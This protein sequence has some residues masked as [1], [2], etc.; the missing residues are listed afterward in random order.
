MYWISCTNLL[1]LH[2]VTFL[3]FCTIPSTLAT[4]TVLS[5]KVR[6]NTACLKVCSTIYLFPS[7]V[8][9]PNYFS[10]HFS[11]T[12]SFHTLPVSL[13]TNTTYHIHSISVFQFLFSRSAIIHT[14]SVNSH[15]K[16]REHVFY[17]EPFQIFKPSLDS[18]TP[19]TGRKFITQNNYKWWKLF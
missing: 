13:I 1:T 11:G 14:H 3:D 8:T 19:S 6:M 9:P 2:T 15:F 7:D 4:F 10:F 5:I 17:Y 18:N 12:T 16:F